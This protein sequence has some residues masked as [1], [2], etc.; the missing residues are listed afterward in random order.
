M[1]TLDGARRGAEFS[2]G[3]HAGYLWWL[4]NHPSSPWEVGGKRKNHPSSP[5]EVGGKGAGVSEE[6]AGGEAEPVAS[7]GS[8]SSRDR[9]RSCGKYNW[10]DS[11]SKY[12]ESRATSLARL[13]RESQEH[14]GIG[15]G[16]TI[17]IGAIAIEGENV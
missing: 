7:I 15:R 2:L 14:P 8:S 13:L 11:G 6:G 5:W 16:Q 17:A 1:C 4:K 9:T 3:P 10:Y 12:S